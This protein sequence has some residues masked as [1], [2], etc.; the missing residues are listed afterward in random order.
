[1]LLLSITTYSQ[2]TNKIK[3]GVE[4]TSSSGLTY[5]IFDLHKKEMK[6]DSGD[7][8]TV[9]YMG[10]LDNGDVFDASYL[11][12]E[13]ISFPLGMGRV[14]KGWEEG[15]QLLHKNDSAL[16][17]IP[18]NLAYGDRKV[19]S[20]PA[21]S[22]LHFW[23]KVVDIKKARKPFS[24]KGAKKV[25]LDSGL[26]YYR[27]KKG[28]GNSIAA[29]NKAYMQYTG[30][31]MDGKKF[32]S[33]YDNDAKAFQFILGRN[34]VIKGWEMAVLGMKTS[35]IRK[36]YVPY[37]YAYGEDGRQPIPPK[38]DLIFDVELEKIETISYPKFA[39]EGKDTIYL[40]N[41]LKYIVAHS[42]EGV[43]VA[44]NDTVVI[45]YTGYFTDGRVFDSSYDR[46]D[47]L[48]FPIAAQRVINGLDMGILILR[49]GDKARFIIPYNL[50][51][52]EQGRAPII[53]PKSDL[54]F[55]IYLKDVRPSNN[56]F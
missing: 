31:F 15:L 8:I 52:G 30:Y 23:V 2:N 12:N 53:P 48:V 32:D 24:I 54:I 17:V 40:E 33:S 56:D 6:A 13:P 3:I 44:P 49:K 18:A 50:A 41:G 46:N 10:K 9:H 16:F 45:E 26:Y 11:R 55:D 34:R 19:G 43:N 27:I 22:V 5:T 21:N 35:E 36:I 37:K 7:V 20:I 14:I 47:S 4:Y 28:K 42:E 51:Y 39:L 38:A 29:G 25:E 1:M